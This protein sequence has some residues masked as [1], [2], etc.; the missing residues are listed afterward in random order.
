MIILFSSEDKVIRNLMTWF[1]FMIAGYK[2]INDYSSTLTLVLNLYNYVCIDIH[3]YTHRGTHVQLAGRSKSK[4][5]FLKE[6]IYYL[7]QAAFAK[8]KARSSLHCN[9]SRTE[10]VSLIKK[11]NKKT[12]N[13][14]QTSIYPSTVL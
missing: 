2:K 7:N 10:Q 4:P 1:R 13:S 8:R 3:K 6:N 5:A 14:S 12:L 11:P 9:K